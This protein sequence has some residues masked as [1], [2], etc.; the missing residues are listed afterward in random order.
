MNQANK[1]H[2]RFF[3]NFGP[4]FDSRKFSISD[5]RTSTRPA[6]TIELKRSRFINS[7]MDALETPRSR[8]ASACEIRSLAESFFFF[9]G[10]ENYLDN[11]RIT[12]YNHPNIVKVNQASER[13]IWR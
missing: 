13:R 1:L 4:G 5:L 6:M 11:V 7:L 3:F 9:V 8:A 12:A 10:I 2:H